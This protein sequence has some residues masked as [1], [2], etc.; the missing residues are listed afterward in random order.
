MK[1]ATALPPLNFRKTGKA[2]PAITASAAALIQWILP[3]VSLSASQ[4]AQK[5]LT[6]SS[7]RVMIAAARPVVRRTLVAP[8]LPLPDARTSAPVFHLTTRN[9][10]GIAPMRYAA[11]S[12]T[13]GRIYFESGNSESLVYTEP[14]GEVRLWKRKK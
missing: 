3:P 8:M 9:P 10:N 11:A 14:D 2:W 5:P 6:I 12:A 1:L 13:S 7:R 4:T